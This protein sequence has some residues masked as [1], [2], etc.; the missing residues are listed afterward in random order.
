MREYI[1]IGYINKNM[2]ISSYELNRTI[3]FNIIFKK[4]L[5][6]QKI[7]ETVNLLSEE[8][9]RNL[10]MYIEVD[11]AN[12]EREILNCIY[13]KKN[14]D[15]FLV[16]MQTK[17]KKVLGL[18]TSIINFLEK[19]IKRRKNIDCSFTIDNTVSRENT[20]II[21]NLDDN[22]LKKIVYI[23]T[24]LKLLIEVLIQNI[25]TNITHIIKQ[26]KE[27]ENNVYND[28]DYESITVTV[29]NDDELS[30]SI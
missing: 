15:H 2:S 29:N 10:T 3:I 28:T 23:L 12:K 19:A 8:S 26:I 13:N 17:E 27:L 20:E 16:K 4:L 24:K 7:L 1:I 9:I 6:I 14:Y 11:I 25:S 22:K 30:L 18:F 5:K 21:N